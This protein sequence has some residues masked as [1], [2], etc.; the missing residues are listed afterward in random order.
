[1]EMEFG[2]VMWFVY[3]RDGERM[4]HHP[5]LKSTKRK[6][7]PATVICNISLGPKNQIDTSRLIWIHKSIWIK[8]KFEFPKYLKISKLV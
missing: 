1:M 7:G 3:K 2:K 5:T 4:T 8:N 6:F